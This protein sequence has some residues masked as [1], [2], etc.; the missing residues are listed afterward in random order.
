[1]DELSPEKDRTMQR[2]PK[3][4]AVQEEDVDVDE[5]HC[6]DSLDNN[7]LSSRRAYS[8]R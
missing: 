6:E 4:I 5:E 1:M 2:W 8:H 3:R 7:Q